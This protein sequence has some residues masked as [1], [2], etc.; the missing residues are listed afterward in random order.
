MASPLKI[1]SFN[2]RGLAEKCKRNTVLQHLKKKYKGIYL[3][4]ETHSTAAIEK[5][6]KGEF[7]GNIFYSHGTSGSKG[8]AI[9]VPQ[10]I[11]LCV[12]NEIKDSEGRFLVLD[13]TINKA[14]YV[15]CNVYAPT[16]DKVTEQQSF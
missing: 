2:V 6:W 14:R 5:K 4:Q 16:K 9:L 1:Y 15:I 10:Y 11:D 13:A 12:H 3:L 7:G 8:V